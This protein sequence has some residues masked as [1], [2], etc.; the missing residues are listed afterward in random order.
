MT[1]DKVDLLKNFH[2]EE[3]LGFPLLRDADAKHVIAFGIRDQNYEKGSN[4]YGIPYPG[5]LLLNP[6]G[7]VIAKFAVK[8]YR[9]RPPLDLVYREVEIS[10]ASNK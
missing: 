2:E 8:G 9:D 3:A 7:L 4:A 5:M 10:L 1:Y 6:E